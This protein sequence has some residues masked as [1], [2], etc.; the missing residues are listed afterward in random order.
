MYNFLHLNLLGGLLITHH[1]L[2][3]EGIELIESF[4]NPIKKTRKR[5]IIKRNFDLGTSFLRKKI[6]NFIT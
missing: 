5:Q 6:F 3:I 4:P 1:S 2:E